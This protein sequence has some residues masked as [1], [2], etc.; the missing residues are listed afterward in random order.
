MADLFLLI[1]VV[2]GAG[3]LLSVLVHWYDAEPE[4]KS[5]EEEWFV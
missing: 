3:V 1:A 5:T 2:V 4:Q